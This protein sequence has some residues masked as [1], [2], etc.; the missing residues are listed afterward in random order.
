[1]HILITNDDGY[2]STGLRILA[3]T[4]LEAG[5]SVLVVAPIVQQSATSHSMSIEKP[6]MAKPFSFGDINGYAVNGFPVDCVRIAPCLTDKNIDFCIAGINDGFNAG[7]AVYYSGTDGAAREAAMNYIPSMALSIGSSATE[8]ILRGFAKS[9]VGKIGFLKSNPM[10]R[11]CFLNVNSPAV[12]HEQTKGERMATISQGFFTDGYISRISPLN[13]PYFWPECRGT[14]EEAEP[15]SDVYYLK[16]GYI[17]YTLVGGYA[18]HNSTL[19][20]FI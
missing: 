2:N 1:M 18:D 20:G 8:E 6:L 15:G 16:K 17:T 9:A 19:Q 12:L 7:A 11:M 13:E 14:Y 10:P 5:H 3:E 4:C